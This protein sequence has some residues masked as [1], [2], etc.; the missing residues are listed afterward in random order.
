VA[1]ALPLSDTAAVLS[2]FGGVDRSSARRPHA[3]TVHC[4]SDELP[5]LAEDL[6][7]TGTA[8]LRLVV[9]IDSI[10]RAGAATVA[11]LATAA[12]A[13]LSI[14]GPVAIDVAR[15][16]EWIELNK[17][18]LRHG[19]PL[20]WSGHVPAQTRDQLVHLVPARDQAEWRKVWR[21]G[22]LGWRRGPGFA[23]VVD[24]RTDV[25]QIT[26]DLSVVT[27]VFGPELDCPAHVPDVDVNL[28]AELVGS[29]L[30]MVVRDRAVWL[31]YRTCRWPVSPLL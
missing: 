13:T 12:V 1:P 19:L 8:G 15:L 27:D 10:P 23:A 31:P 16:P 3:A 5:D 26:V 4:R 24:A 20:A 29:R 2:A 30:V 25:R 9:R 28:L 22:M 17:A 7:R 18:A 21:Y 11:H 14:S 6:A